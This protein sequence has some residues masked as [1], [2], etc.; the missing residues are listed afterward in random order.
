ME[1]ETQTITAADVGKLNVTPA[2]KAAPAAPP[3]IITGDDGRKYRKMP[4]GMLAPIPDPV[5]HA[6][7]MIAAINAGYTL[8][9]VRL[10]DPKSDHANGTVVT[11][12]AEEAAPVVAA[13]KAVLEARAA[14]L[15]ATDA[16]AKDATAPA[17]AAK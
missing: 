4:N 7:Q 17:A 3:V 15:A 9:G 1:K 2:A 16:A 14:A 6:K 5:A 13:V 12:S 10:S 11:L 8:T